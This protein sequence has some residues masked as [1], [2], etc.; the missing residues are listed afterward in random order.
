MFKKTLIIF[1]LVLTAVASSAVKPN[2]MRR[3]DKAAMNRWVDSVYNSLDERQRIAQLIVAKVVPTRE[4]SEIATFVRKNQVGGLLFTEGTIN[5]FALCTNAA[6][7]AAKVPLLMTLDG[8]WGLAMRVSGTTKFP[9][10][11]AL[12]AMSNPELAREYGREVGRQCRALGI[13]VNFAPDA[14]VNSN[15]SNPVIGYRSFGENPE[16]VARLVT[17]YSQGLEETGIQAVAKHFPGHGDT[18][19]DS[20]KTLPLVKKNMKQLEETELVPFRAFIDAGCSG[21]MTGHISVPSLDKSGTPASLSPKI[22]GLLRKNLGFE[23]LIYT[24]ALGMQGAQ[25]KKKNNCV[26]A[27]KAGADILLC[28]TD[29]PASIDAIQT[30]VRKGKLSKT[31]IEERVRHV[32]AYKFALGLNHRPQPISLDG[33]DSSLNTRSASNTDR[34]LTAASMTLL[35]NNG[36]ILPLKGLDTRSIAVVLLGAKSDNE[37]AERCRRYAP[38]TVYAAPEGSLSAGQLAAIKKHNTVIAAV[39]D[40]KSSEIVSLKALSGVRNLV[41]VFM[42][43]PYKMAKFGAIVKKADAVLLAYDDK[44]LSRDYAAQAVFGGISTSGKLPVD[45]KGLYPM[46]TGISTAKV[47]LGYTTPEMTGLRASLT[48]SIDSICEDAII[49]QAMPGAQVIVAHH[50]D[51]VLDRS[52]GLLTAGG[53]SVNANTIYDL[54]SVSKAIGTLPGIMLAYDRGLIDLDKTAAEYIP[55]LRGTGKDSITVR[56]LLYHESGMPPSLNMFNLMIDSTSY[57]GRLITGKPDADHSI[58]ISEGAYGNNT[59]RLRTDITSRVR[60]PGFEVEAAEGIWVG[61][62]AYDTVMSTIYNIPIRSSNGYTYSCLNFCLLMDAEQHVTGQ[63]HDRFVGDNLWK[64][65]GTSTMSYRPTLSHS[66]SEIAPTENDTYLRRQTV[67]GYVHDETAA[68]SGGVQG[69]A[70][71][72]SNADDIAKMCQMWLNGGTYGGDRIL[73]EETVR[74]FTTDKSPTCRRGLGFD[75]PDK[76]NPAWSPTCGEASPETF[77]H[78]GF[79]GTVFWVDPKNDI[80]LV[81]LTNRVNPTRD[82]PIFNNLYVRPELYRQIYKALPTP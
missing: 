15:P 1:S 32:L 30:A 59:G 11:M 56:Q 39:F 63:S 50:G 29:I 64:K 58:R 79:T 10:N 24:D 34:Y 28:P 3:V 13:Q 82:T 75:K 54:A 22:T 65:L 68:F 25:L 16:H 37:F 9:T 7:E 55:G 38:V 31:L 2:I 4:P 78:L 17:A 74:L 57:T 46:G 72:F 40:N 49:R 26:E 8:E 43:N 47:R 53:D 19:S 45:L 14:D 18:N 41:E 81:F 67:H 73:S 21:I 61:K 69:N 60:K 5:Q 6:Q 44:P 66:K 27:L 33:L 70:G 20:H 23:G 12:G 62:A 48:D 76:V 42:I 35:Q 77:G 52:Y 36:N 80:I 71:L 51:I